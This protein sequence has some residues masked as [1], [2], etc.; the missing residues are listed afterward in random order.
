MATVS[1]I[2][3]ERQGS[4]VGTCDGA[5]VSPNDAAKLLKAQ[6]GDVIVEVVRNGALASP[7]VIS[8]Y[9]RSEG[10]RLESLRK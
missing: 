7:S 5:T 9:V 8:W 1:V 3:L 2:I 4:I 6:A 10:I